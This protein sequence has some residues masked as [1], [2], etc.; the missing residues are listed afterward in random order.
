M[1]SLKNIP[2][3]LLVG[4]KGTRLQSVVSS[5]PKPLAPVGEKSF[6][7]LLIRQL[8]SQGIR[9]LV[10]CS[11]YL[12]D[13]IENELG[14]G[15]ALDVA[16]RYSKE[17]EP[18]GT[19][20]ALKLA[21]PLL[22]GHSDFLVMN[23]DSFL[24]MDIPRFVEFHHSKNGLFSVA[25]RRVENAAR[26][27]TVEIDQ[28]YRITGFKEKTGST[29]SG[30]INGGVYVFKSSLLA[31]IPTGPSSLERDILPNLLD[32]G[33]YALEQQGMFIDIGTPEDYARAQELCESMY[34]AATR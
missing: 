29:A 30:L 8:R 32:R 18:L 33:G 14:D 28:H 12:A 5:K 27:G 17:N 23:G 9:E 19:A 16:I 26:Y 31:S 15:R 25:V 3:V 34:R 13:Q 20:G 24:E 21:E 10:M 11:G 2:A 4:G 7:H 6:L 22:A 1:E